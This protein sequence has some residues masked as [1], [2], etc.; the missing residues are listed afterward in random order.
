M[1]LP[2]TAK[3]KVVHGVLAGGATLLVLM[4][5]LAVC[6]VWA[7]LVRVDPD[8]RIQMAGWIWL[9]IAAGAAV[10]A[11]AGFVAR[12]VGRGYRAVALLARAIGTVGLLEAVI[13][14]MFLQDQSRLLAV[15][16]PMVATIAILLGGLR[17]GEFPSLW[18]H[19]TKSGPFSA[20]WSYGLPLAVFLAATLVALFGLPHVADGSRS[21]VVAA[22]L[23]LDF[24]FAAPALAY[25]LFVRKRRLPWLTIVPFVVVGFA[26]A[27]VTLP[28]DHHLTLNVLRYLAIPAELALLGYLAVQ[29]HHAYRRGFRTNGD[30]ATRLR[31]VTRHAL[32]SRIPADIV[33][34]EIALLYYALG[35][36]REQPISGHIFT[37][38]REVTYGPVLFGL[39]VVLFFETIGVHLLVGQW[40]TTAAW[41]L[42]GLSVYAMIWLIGDYR[43]MVARPIHLTD[44]HLKLRVGLRWEADIPRDCIA[45]I[46]MV[47]S[48][49]PDTRGAL[50]VSLLGQPN[51]R[52][53]LKKPVDVV[54]MYGILKTTQEI[55]FTVDNPSSFWKLANPESE[56]PPSSHSET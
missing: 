8:G 5:V 42:T 41:I 19:I 36:R 4:A 43:A 26:M 33:T 28:D 44:D 11:F 1:I 40:S 25:F 45:S 16:A 12:R 2:E 55:W 49:N 50:K 20:A 13:L 35:R 46:E 39:M 34:T 51:V 3:P 37:V 47:G 38:Y 18:G 53:R 32:K 15:F 23:T 10:S 56:P 54:G 29:A 27:T 9:E 7:G 21:Q 48:L 6:A 31:T 22:A 30:F 52:L 14:L 17:T 24:T